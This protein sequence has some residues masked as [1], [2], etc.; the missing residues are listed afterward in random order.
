[1]RQRIERRYA[2]VCETVSIREYQFHFTRIADPDD[3]ARHMPGEADPQ[4]APQWQPYWAAH[5]DASW[6][7][8]HVLLDEPLLDRNVL[9][10]G[11]G[12][13][14]TGAVAAVQGA[15]VWMADAAQ[16]AL[17]FAR[18]NTWPWRDR[19][20]VRRLDWRTDRLAGQRFDL[21]VGADI[22]YDSEDWPYLDRFWVEHLAAGGRVLLGESGRRTGRV[23]S[24]L[25]SRPRV[26]G[27]TVHRSSR[28]MRP[29]AADHPRL[30]DRQ[31]RLKFT[32]LMEASQNGSRGRK[33]GERSR[34]AGLAVFRRK[35]E[36]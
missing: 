23:V 10:L 12:L 26:A 28:P 25:A 34:M 27:R 6:A 9:D 20:R 14:L 29:P 36:I 31:I 21:I 11:C 32:T 22:I 1:L 18:L 33:S 4:A 5:W 15:R 30:A 17:L 7:I 13:G 2:T 8:A 24:R 35:I 19:V 16:P 3:M